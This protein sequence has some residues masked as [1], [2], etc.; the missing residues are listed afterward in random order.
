MVGDEVYAVGN[1][2]GLEGTF[3]RGIVSGIRQIGSE[4]LFQITA[5]ISPG[6]SGGPILDTRGKVIG[7]AM[8]TFKGG[9]SLN[10][11]IPVAYLKSLLSIMHRVTSLSARKSSKKPKSIVHNLGGHS[12]EGVEGG[13]LIW[14]WDKLQSGEYSFSLRNGLRTPVRDVYCLVIFYDRK[15]HPIDVDF[16]QY[17]GFIPVRLA[18]RVTGGVHGSVQKLTTKWG[19]PTPSTKVEIRV[20]DFKIME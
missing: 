3:S 5:P 8:A 18:K 10:F 12:I 14:T 15:G 20:L 6:S 2:L 13:Q 19:S 16:V 11:A 17:T 9:Q 1:P 4:T 7:V